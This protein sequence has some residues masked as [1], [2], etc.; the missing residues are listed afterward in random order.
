M[1]THSDFSNLDLDD[2]LSLA[3]DLEPNET[4]SGL[5][6]DRVTHKP[7]VQRDSPLN[8]S[9]V[10]QT[11][12]AI[13]GEKP[14][15]SRTSLVTNQTH[16]G[17]TN[18]ME[19][20]TPLPANGSA[21]I[22]LSCSCGYRMRLKQN[23]AGT[24]I[25]CPKCETALLVPIGDGARQGQVLSS[26]VA[27]Y[28]SAWEKLTTELAQEIK[29]LSEN[30]SL[31]GFAMRSLRKSVEKVST[32]RY[33]I[34]H[35]RE[36]INQLGESEDTRAYPILETLWEEE[37]PNL[38]SAILGAMGQSKDPR[39]TL[40]LLRLLK[41][42]ISEIR[43]AAIQSL[44]F[45]RD[46]RVVS[47][48]VFFGQSHPELKYAVGDSL[49]KMK[50]D[51]ID[52]LIDLLKSQDPKI[53]SE[54][55]VL[56][57]RLKT[58]DAIKPLMEVFQTHPGPI[59]GQVAEAFGLI[60]EPK[61]IP[62]LAPLLKI[63]DAKIRVQA[64]SAMGRVPHPG[65]LK[66]LIDALNDP[67]P[68]VKKR[69]AMALGEIGDNRAAAGLSKLLTE[70]EAEL[71][72]TAAESLGR[73]GDAQAVPYLIE[74]T[75]DTDESVVLKALGALRKLKS[76]KS[77]DPLTQLLDHESSRIRQR[78]I[79]VLGQVGDAVV[80][81][82]LEQMLRNDR[83][84]DVRAAAA[85]ALG[86]I[87]DPGSV[88]SLIDAL[89]GAFTVRCRAIVALGEIG[90]ESA[91]APLLAML[92]EP[93]PEIRYHATQ[94]LAQMKHELAAKNIE[95]LLT[96]SNAMVRRGAAKALETLGHGD[97]EA[98]LGSTT[99]QGVRRGF[100]QLKNVLAAI[101][102]G[103]MADTIQHG[104]MF[105]KAMTVLIMAS[106]FLL[107]G[108]YYLFLSGGSSSQ[109]GLLIR[110]NVA[111]L[112]ITA[113]GSQLVVGRT[114]GVVEIWDITSKTRT[115][116]FKPFSQGSEIIGV[117]FVAG[118]DQ[119]V[120]SNGTA[121]GGYD[122][123][124]QVVLWEV[125]VSKGK[126][127]TFQPT[128]DRENL[129]ITTS[130][131]IV[132]FLDITTGKPIG[133]GAISL[134][135]NLVKLTELSNNGT[136]IACSGGRDPIKVWST[137]DGAEIYEYNL[138]PGTNI[139]AMQFSPDDQY[140]A[141]SD[142]EGFL[143]VIEV[144]SGKMFYSLEEPEISPTGRPVA[145]SR[146][147]YNTDGME[148]FGFLAKDLAT[149]HLES[150]SLE[151]QEISGTSGATAF[152]SQ[153]GGTLLALGKDDEPEVYVVDRISGDTQRFN[154]IQR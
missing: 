16:S 56:L 89:H 10:S 86:E 88:D 43:L 34:D 116:I 12:P 136:M 42:P 92:K 76:P 52:P 153:P 9:A 146:L 74:M 44:A 96:D 54:S 19:S 99:K 60:G 5:D 31:S 133:A 53:V 127:Q 141:V 100:Q 119:V 77:I 128:R 121:V 46:A 110:G 6:T 125:P 39:G 37:P 145:F 142:D 138:F 106:P 62:T 131:G 27:G 103:E 28:E 101:S 64:A 25:K 38:Q 122:L 111:S 87:R 148:L 84:E 147:F 26:A 78:S 33:D 113:D 65:C 11:P 23:K 132:T 120:V 109:S 129:M 114:M 50:E 63:P 150:G 3:E 149:I 59:Q 32:E 143:K 70:S 123:A 126:I 66:E 55:V 8:G 75:H 140:L 58:P 20:S 14:A 61:C 95:P 35:V 98:L 107:A 22:R 108:G 45:T 79:D 69:C 2:L 134:P 36:A 7:H 47:L 139:L 51:A 17:A 137:A 83:S 13:N 144:E 118:K 93:A 67:N 68:E 73:I 85:K 29:N 91:L 154:F 80:A 135:P 94:A 151:R 15:P 97:A 72:I 41:N 49:L 48:L 4:V 112:D 115:E 71:K 57:G 90:E 40:F 105:L 30:K 1:S 152:V 82:Q 130:A 104:S 81:E 117:S 102:P 24:K 18:N 21:F 124:Q